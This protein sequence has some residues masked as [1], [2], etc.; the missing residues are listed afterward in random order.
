MLETASVGAATA[1]WT[2]HASDSQYVM[3]RFDLMLPQVVI[4]LSKA[5]S[6]IHIG[7]DGWT[8]KGSKRSFLGVVTQLARGRTSWRASQRNQLH[9]DAAAAR[10][11]RNIPGPSQR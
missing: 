2:P 7:F 4:D 8:T 10:A 3:R 6:K 1:L 9:Q 5:L 11:F